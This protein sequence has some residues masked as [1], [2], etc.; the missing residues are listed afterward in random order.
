MAEVFT[1]VAC[2]SD[3][4]MLKGR[5]YGNLILIGTDSPLPDLMAT[6]KITRSLL[7][8]GVPA[9]YK[10]DAWTRS[11]MASGIPRFDPPI[12]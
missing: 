7:G 3:P 5:R 9:Q 10:D 11:F 4:A 12:A 2:I 6:Q 8:G 1:H